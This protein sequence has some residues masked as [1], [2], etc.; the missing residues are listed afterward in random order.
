MLTLLTV[1]RYI[2]KLLGACYHPETRAPVLIM[3]FVEGG[4]LRQLLLSSVD[5]SWRER[6]HMLEDVVKGV[7]IL[8]SHN[9]P[10]CEC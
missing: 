7:Q 5:L 4:S 1:N 8:H 2:V 9:P 3:E 10:V 6:L